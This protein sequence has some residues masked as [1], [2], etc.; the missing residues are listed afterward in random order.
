[1]KP[2][3][4]T[5]LLI[6][7]SVIVFSCSKEREN[8]L[9]KT[10]LKGNIKA[11]R[12][13][14][15]E[16]FGSADTLVKGDIIDNQGAENSYTLYNTKGNITDLIKYDNENSIKYKW[17]FHYDKK[18]VQQLSGKR[19]EA[20]DSE[21][22][23][24]A[25]IYDKKKNPVEYIHY[26]SDGNIK[27]RTVSKFGKQ[28][29]VTEEKVFDDKNLL[30]KTSK[31]KYK[32]NKLV[33][34]RSFDKDGNLLIRSVYSYDKKG[35]MQTMIMV[36]GKNNP[37]SQGTYTYN[38]EGFIQTEVLKRPGYTD[39]ILEYIYV[40]DI[41]GNWTQRIMLSENEAFQI[42]RRQIE[43]YE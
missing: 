28:G 1:M 31:F 40:T 25:Y 33:E 29:N 16:A 30:K 34:G 10:G 3:I 21:E 38:K 12:E 14:S 9:Q 32:K 41:Q 20:K 15:Y 23:S 17:R 8:D 39:L 24:S 35:N 22:D 19:Y 2:L 43:Y 5:I 37:I 7:L 13:I 4:N 6:F 27:T 26:D 18:G 11:I 42:T 36:D